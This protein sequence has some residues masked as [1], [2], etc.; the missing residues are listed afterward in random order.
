MCQKIFG[1]VAG[2]A[3]HNTVNTAWN[4]KTKRGFTP[5]CKGLGLFCNVFLGYEALGPHECNRS[6]LSHSI[7]EEY[8][9]KGKISME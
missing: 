4:P 8:I 9:V 6:D 2:L 7:K 3:R 1:E 5:F